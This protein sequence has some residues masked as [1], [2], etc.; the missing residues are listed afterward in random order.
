MRG[1]I[2]AKGGGGGDIRQRIL[3]GGG[4]GGGGDTL[5]HRLFSGYVGYIPTWI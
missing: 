3:P 1:A 4:G 5:G 2:Y